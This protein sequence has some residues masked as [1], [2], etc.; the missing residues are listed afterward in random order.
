MKKLMF[1]LPVI[2]FAG[3]KVSNII[4]YSGVDVIIQK[5]KHNS[6]HLSKQPITD[7]KVIGKTMLIKPRNYMFGKHSSAIINFANK[8]EKLDIKGDSNVVINNIKTNHL[9]IDKFGSG[10][11]SIKGHIHLSNIIQSGSNKIRVMW[12]D[13]D[14]L[15][16][17]GDYGQI[18]LA[19][20]CKD[21]KVLGKKDFNFNGRYLRCKNAW[22]RTSDYAE[23]TVNPQRFINAWASDNS[24]IFYNKILDYKNHNTFSFDKALIASIS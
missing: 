22:V 24:K 8:L 16:V 5:A 4:V 21:L 6:W 12:V 7:I 2:V 11:V 1:F 14:K 3:S 18:E 9:D 23:V 20:R 19:G 13:S 10:T 15:K 17:T